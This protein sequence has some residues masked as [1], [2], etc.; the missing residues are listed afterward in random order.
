MPLFIAFFA[1]ALLINWLGWWLLVIIVTPILGL[2]LLAYI[3]TKRGHIIWPIKSTSTPLMPV[4]SNKAAPVLNLLIEIKSSTYSPAQKLTSTVSSNDSNPLM[5]NV[6]LVI[7]EAPL[8]R[9][10]DG[11]KIWEMR[12][13]NTLKR[14]VIALAKKGSSQIFGLAEIIDSKGPLTDETLLAT[15]H[16]HGITQSR[17]AD[18]L[19]KKYRYAWVLTNVRRLPNSVPYHHT[20]GAQSFV[21]LD[22]DTT[23]A[24]VSMIN[25]A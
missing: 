3:E 10:L 8:E 14:G 4:T 2:L 13:Q 19:V 24:I 11:R 17:L 23:D 15:S 16:F 25:E 22:R 20:R 9:I 12:P 1:A 6:A 5:P 18:P 21:R 7:K